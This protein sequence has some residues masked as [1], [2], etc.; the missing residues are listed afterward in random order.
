M[1]DAAFYKE[2]I[3]IRAQGTEAFCVSAAFQRQ[4]IALGCRA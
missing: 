2:N 3:S 4:E 1:Y